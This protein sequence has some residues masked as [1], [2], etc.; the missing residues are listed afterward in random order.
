MGSHGFQG[1]ITFLEAGHAIG[2]NVNSAFKA[3]LQAILIALQ[4]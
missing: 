1:Y 4:H 2:S 3:E